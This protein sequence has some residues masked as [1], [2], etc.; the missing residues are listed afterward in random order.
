MK[1]ERCR[2]ATAETV[3]EFGFKITTELYL[4]VLLYHW[5]L[6]G[7]SG[8]LR[9]KKSTRGE[10]VKNC[11]LKRCK[12]VSANL[13]DSST[14][15][16]HYW[17]WLANEVRK[18]VLLCHFVRPTNCK[19]P[20]VGG[21]KLYTVNF[22]LS[23]PNSLGRQTAWRLPV[24]RQCRVFTLK[25]HLETKSWM[26]QTAQHYRMCKKNLNKNC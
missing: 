4:G 1:L 25:W 10:Q 14:K 24:V 21:C 16:R 6:K 19:S 8:N 2:F 15:S 13:L 23:P 20:L 12:I 11:F 3:T 18:F 17:Q 26:L 9:C 22:T 7:G 5:N